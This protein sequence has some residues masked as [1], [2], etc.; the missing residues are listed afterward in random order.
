MTEDTYKVVKRD[1]DILKENEVFH[2]LRYYA[3]FNGSEP[4]LDGS[5]NDPFIQV[6]RDGSIVLNHN[7]KYIFLYDDEWRGIIKAINSAL[8][9]KETKKQKSYDDWL[10]STIDSIE[11]FGTKVDMTRREIIKVIESCSIEIKSKK[12]Y[13]IPII[14]INN[15][16]YELCRTDLTDDIA[17]ISATKKTTEEW[18]EYFLEK[19][20][21]CYG[22]RIKIKRKNKKI[23]AIIDALTDG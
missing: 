20:R 3:T 15:E 6:S 19:A 9:D 23:L 16:R 4:K 13:H 2:V 8:I 21:N 18:R 1:I 17:T 14:T 22:G 10:N 7:E 11:F 5:F 12:N